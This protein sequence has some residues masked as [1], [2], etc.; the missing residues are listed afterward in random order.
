[1]K[2]EKKDDDKFKM[3]LNIAGKNYPLFLE[4]PEDEIYY[5]IAQKLINN[6]LDE[7]HN[8]FK[9]LL[10][11]QDFLAIIAVD[12]LLDA[13]K[14]QESYTQLQQDV[15]ERLNKLEKEVSIN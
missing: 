9:G 8:R 11:T 7:Y 3:S 10:N 15:F 14:L 2:I 5:R 13:Q 1:M 4:I 6:K 12:A